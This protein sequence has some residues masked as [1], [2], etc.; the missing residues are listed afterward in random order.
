MNH[1]QSSVGSRCSLSYFNE[2]FYRSRVIVPSE[3]SAF[4]NP[5][6][7]LISC[8]LNL[9]FSNKSINIKKSQVSYRDLSEGLKSHRLPVLLYELFL[10]YHYSFILYNKW[11]SNIK[12]I[13]LKLIITNH[14]R[15]SFLE[16]TWNSKHYKQIIVLPNLKRATKYI[17]HMQWPS[18]SL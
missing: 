10:L 8:L 17:H 15:C 6:P 2:I 5:I 13:L 18:K 1:R 3:N 12:T 4:T 7:K 16:L 14:N 9:Y 11:N